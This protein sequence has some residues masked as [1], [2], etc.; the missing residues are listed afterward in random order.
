MAL[1][2]L[3]AVLLA[4]VPYLAAVRRAPKLDWRRTRWW[5]AALALAARAGMLALPVPFGD[6]LYRYW[7]E[8]RVQLTGENPYRHAPQAAELTGLRDA[9]WE[10]VGHKEV[11]SAY[12][13]GL[14]GGFHVGARLGRSP[15][16]FRWIFTAFDLAIG[17]LLV[18]LLRASGQ[19]ESLSLIWLLNP[20][21]IL[22][23][24]GNGH[25]MSL[26]I[27][28][29]VAGLWLLART[30]RTDTCTA[31]HHMAAGIAFASAALAHVMAWPVILSVIAAE[32][33]RS[34][35]FWLAFA[36]ILALCSWPAIAAGKDALLGLMNVAGRWRPVFDR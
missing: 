22:E 10:H 1:A 15:D 34:W 9:N 17:W 35:R 26:P 29:F 30:S 23:F 18:R 28:M 13:P 21:V 33:M 27:C 5:I 32:R 4:F 24:A 12:P 7:W 11:P 19:N 3:Y 2:L 20:L 25:E 16:V 36:G 8:G 31:K 6:D 14:L